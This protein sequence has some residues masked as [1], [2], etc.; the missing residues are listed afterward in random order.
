[1]Q[2]WFYDCFYQ[3]LFSVYPSCRPLFKG[4]LQIQGRALVRMISTCLEQLTD[5]QTLAASLQKLAKGHAAKGVVSNEYFLV[6]EVLLW[7]LD[8]CLGVQFD[9]A[10]KEVW[11]KI[12]SRLL[13]EII[14]VAVQEEEEAATKAVARA[15]DSS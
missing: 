13:D 8:C 10:S 4:D 7:T 12:Y 15:A 9:N 11:I 14:P 5:K 1:V 6:G 3:R 2:A